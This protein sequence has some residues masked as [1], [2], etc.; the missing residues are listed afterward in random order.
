MGHGLELRAVSNAALKSL[1][2]KELVYKSADGYM[3]YDRFM[4]DVAVAELTS[5]SNIYGLRDT[6]LGRYDRNVPSIR[7]GQCRFAGRK[8]EYPFHGVHSYVLIIPVYIQGC[9]NR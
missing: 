6:L 7:S 2:E 5:R 9:D 8:S 1:V 4:G 3:V